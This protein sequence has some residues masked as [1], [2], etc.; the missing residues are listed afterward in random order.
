MSKPKSERSDATEQR[1]ADAADGSAARPVGR[2]RWVGVAAIVVFLLAGVSVMSARVRRQIDARIPMI[3]DVS[4]KT[5]SFRQALLKADRRARAAP[6]GDEGVGYLGLLYHANHMYEPADACYRLAV[7]IDSDNAR[8][9][10]LLAVLQQTTGAGTA[11]LNHLRMAVE[12]APD[13]VPARL[14]LADLLLKHGQQEQAKHAYEECLRLAPADPY[15]LL[16]LARIAVDREEWSSAASHL[17]RAV[18]FDPD[19][20]AGH[21]LLAT[22]YRQMGRTQA[23]DLA[24]ARADRCSRFRAAPDPW[25]DQLDDLCYDPDYLCIRADTFRRT[26]NVKQAIAFLERAVEVAPDQAKPHRLYGR[27]MRENR[28][29]DVA[30]KHLK[31]AVELDPDDEESRIEM[32]LWLGMQNRVDEAEA[33]IRKAMQ[34]NPK[35][36]SAHYNLG[37]AYRERKNDQEAAVHFLH[38]SELSEYRFDDATENYVA[39][40]V[41][42]GQQQKAIVFLEDLLQR[43]PT[44]SRHWRLLARVYANLND[45]AKS[46]EVIRRGLAR[47]RLDP[48][49]SVSLAWLLAASPQTT[50]D[51]A[52]EAI[53]LAQHAL[54]LADMKSA[55]VYLAALAAA[56]ARAKHFDAAIATIEQA[57]K[58]ARERGDQKNVKQFAEYLE[59]FKAEQPISTISG[60]L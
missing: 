42:L 16:G 30:Y 48:D 53:R 34:I 24:Q 11:V 35:S 56:H 36:P 44:A 21:R 25:M 58:L 41:R 28:V 57:L 33:E 29:F 55:P 49:L 27:A 2:A 1:S 18:Q 15:A 52:E 50:A 8:W 13:Y 19:F 47:A 4:D 43:R 9:P 51:E 26:R 37:M 40:L 20:G 59:R 54:E 17:K 46:E 60:R 38:A 39:C 7:E 12:A 32:G 3:P 14:K 10:Y 31:R 6:G 23:A 22:V 5:E 45:P